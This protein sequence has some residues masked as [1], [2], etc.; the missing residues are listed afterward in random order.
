MSRK[1]KHKRS[2]SRFIRRVKSF[3]LR[4]KGFSGKAARRWVK[5]VWK[6]KKEDK[7]YSK[8]QK[9]QAYRWGFIP[10]EVE[11]LGIT[12]ENHSAILSNREYYYLQPINGTYDKWLRDRISTLNVFGRFREVFE[13]CSYHIIRRTGEPFIIP[14]SDKAEEFEPDVEGLCAYLA[15][16]GPKTISYSTWGSEKWEIGASVDSEGQPLFIFNG[17]PVSMEKFA[18]WLNRVSRKHALVIYDADRNMTVFSPLVVTDAEVVLHVRMINADG[19]RPQFCRAFLEINYKNG[20]IRDDKNT[21]KQG[22]I[23]REWSSDKDLA[24]KAEDFEDILEEEE[25]EKESDDAEDREIGFED[26]VYE[27]WEADTEEKEFADPGRSG[28]YDGKIPGD[29]ENG[30]K[31]PEE[32]C[33]AAEMVTSISKKQ[34]KRQGGIHRFYSLVGL[35]G[36]FSGLLFL[37]KGKRIQKTDRAPGSDKVFEGT[38]PGWEEILD[39]LV[40]MFRIF[41]QIEYVEVRL[42]VEEDGFIITG[43]SPNPPYSSLF[44]FSPQEND[45][46]LSKVR[47]KEEAWQGGA[48]QIKRLLHNTRLKI[49]RTWAVFSSP[50]GLVPYQS[51]RWPHDVWCDLISK[52]GVGLRTKCWA[53]RHGFLSYRISQ[54]GIEKDNWKQFISDFEYRWLRHI[55]NKY[56]YWLEDKITLKYLLREYRECF[57]DYYYYTCFR[58]GQH[59]IVP[60]MDLPKGYGVSAN[61]ILRLAREKG[62]L[63]LKPDKGSHGEGFYRLAWEDGGYTLNGRKASEDEVIGILENPENQYLVMEY[64]RMHAD[65]G[66]IYPGS[67][68]TIRFYIFKRDGRAPQ[69]GAV[70]LRIGTS[71]TGGVDNLAAGGIAAEVDAETGRF[72][73]ALVLDGINQGNLVSCPVHPDTKIPIEGV[74][75]RWEETRSLVL[76]IA[77]SIKQLEYFGFDVAITEDGIKIPEINRFP[78]F[79]RI[80]KLS[81]EAIEYLLY[82]LEYKKHIY[83]YD[84][85]P[86]RKLIR[87]PKR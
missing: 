21:D 4:A 10:V 56:K 6:S 32:Q 5:K 60:M 61:E 55:N 74:L 50:R 28:I 2:L 83:R 17:C 57:P 58:N 64:I 23:F 46:M 84:I 40:N 62:V 11:N 49:R 22:N 59:R 87:L 67:V 27:D 44:R 75:P 34:E 54:Y 79:P 31:N 73:N 7:E 3:V 18:S 1:K 36:M 41:P 35:D 25:N 85:K 30:E 45:F 15:D 70:Y 76:E 20:W 78:D 68:N 12:E 24:D 69:I 37:D 53:Y 47:L 9:K 14:L 48:V 39:F 8:A 81:P 82:R 51:T 52:N 63:A 43:M 38:I 42:H 65:I 26:G 71:A 66:R 33:K 86:C 29:M 77:R 16:Q 72:G 19:I 80:V 13:P